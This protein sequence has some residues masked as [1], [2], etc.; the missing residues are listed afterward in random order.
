MIDLH[1]YWRRFAHLSIQMAAFKKKI[2]I[3]LLPEVVALN[4][5]HNERNVRY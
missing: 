3:I 2:G 4:I 5:E 1:N